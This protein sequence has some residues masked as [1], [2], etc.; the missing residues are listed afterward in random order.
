MIV[1]VWRGLGWIV[2]FVLI[3]AACGGVFVQVLLAQQGWIGIA[4]WA[5][6]IVV[7]LGAVTLSLLGLSL[8]KDRCKHDFFF[9]SVSHW[10]TVLG[11]FCVALIIFTWQHPLKAP[12]HRAQATQPAPKQKQVVQ[13]TELVPPTVQHP[14]GL[15][16]DQIYFTGLYLTG[17]RSEWQTSLTDFTAEGPQL[18]VQQKLPIAA[19]QWAPGRVYRELFLRKGER[20]FR[21]N[22]RSEDETE[23]RPNAEFDKL[24]S[25]EAIAFDSKRSRLLVST[26]GANSTLCAY[27]VASQSWSVL[28]QPGLDVQVL[29]YVSD[30]DVLY[31]L[32]AGGS[33]G[34]GGLSKFDADG[35]RLSTVTLPRTIQGGHQDPQMADLH[36][37]EPHLIVVGYTIGVQEIESAIYLLEPATGKIVYTGPLKLRTE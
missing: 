16:L 34:F 10:G 30:E 4:T 13:A 17:N 3:S 32:Q 26:A 15:D 25:L 5:G 6:P 7:A 9:I 2:P 29:T 28:Q 31:G 21:Y 35:K 33:G 36:Y 23:I 24:S 19:E 22:R 11:A 1:L 20:L 14:P 37:V 18:D 27:D 12:P 8:Q